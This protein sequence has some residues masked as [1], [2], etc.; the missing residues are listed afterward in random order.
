MARMRMTKK[1]GS[2]W[3]GGRTTLLGTAMKRKDYDNIEHKPVANIQ[4]S[5]NQVHVRAL[6][7]SQSNRKWAAKS[8][9]LGVKHQF[10]AFF[11]IID[12]SCIAPMSS[13]C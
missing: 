9:N 4:Y 3:R 11:F 7:N 13:L 10:L 5:L 12:E 8:S 2:W 6:T 1:E